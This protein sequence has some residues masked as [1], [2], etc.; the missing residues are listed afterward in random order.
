MDENKE[1]TRM[2]DNKPIEQGWCACP[3]L[4]KRSR[5]S[6]ESTGRPLR[7]AVSISRSSL[8]DMLR[9]RTSKNIGKG[10]VGR[11][12]AVEEGGIT[13]GSSG[14]SGRH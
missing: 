13:S 9:R 10:G 7:I 2:T 11:L 14:R 3:L 12:V 5:G 6:R 1:N 4:N 8:G